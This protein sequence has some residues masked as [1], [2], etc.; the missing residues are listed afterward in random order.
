MMSLDDLKR[1]VSTVFKM[2]GLSL[3]SEANRYLCKLLSE[4][5]TQAKLNLWIDKIVENVLKQPLST[6]MVNLKN[7]K[8]AITE[9]SNRNH[10]S[11]QSSRILSVMDAFSLPKLTYSEE[12]KK[13]IR[14]DLLGF[15]PPTL[16]P[17]A[18]SKSLLFRERFSILYQLTSRHELFTPAVF[19]V[20]SVESFKKFQLYPI[21]YL[22]G[23]TTKMTDLVVLGMLS[24]IEEFHSGIFTEN[25]FVLAEGWYEDGIFQATAIGFPPI[26]NAAITRSYFG[27]TNFLGGNEPSFKSSAQLARIEESNEDAML[28]ILSEVWLDQVKQSVVVMANYKTP[29]AFNDKKPYNRWVEEIKAWKELTDLEETKQGLAI[30]LSLPEDDSTSIRDKVFNEI[31][32]EDLKKEDG[33]E[34]LIKFMDNI[35]KQDELSEAYEAYAEFDRHKRSGQITMEMY[36]VEFEKLYHRTKKFKMELPEA[37]R[38]F[39]LLE[40]A[41]LE[42]KDRQLVLTGVDYTE[43]NSLCKQMGNSLRKFFGKQSMGANDKDVSSSIKIE[44]AFIAEDEAYFTRPSNWSKNYRGNFRGKPGGSGYTSNRDRYGKPTAQLEWR[45]GYRGSRFGDSERSGTKKLNPLGPDGNPLRCRSCESIRHML[46]ECPDS[47][48]N[49][50][51]KDTEKAVLFT[52]NQ[53]DERRVF[54]TEAMTSAVLDSACTSTVAGE[55]WTKLYIDSLSPENAAQVTRCESETV[56]KFG[57]GRCLKSK[58]KITFPCLIAGVNCN[59]STDVVESDIPLLLSK[60][61]MKTAKMKLDLENDSA[62]IFGKHVDLQC[63]SSGHYCVSLEQPPTLVKDTACVLFSALQKGPVEKLSV[64]EKLHKQFAHPTGQRLKSLLRDADVYDEEYQKCVDEISNNC[65]V[66]KRYKKTPSRPIVALPLATEF[67]QVVAMDL[68]EWKP[69]VYFFHLIDM[70]TRFSLASV[71]KNKTPAVITEKIMTLWIGGGMGTP[72]KFLA[73]NGGEFANADYRD[74]AE[75]L[76][77]EVWNTAGLS[78]W[79]NGLCERNH[80]VVDDCVA[81]ILEDNPALK[82]D[83]ALVWAVNAKNALQMVHGWSPYQLVFGIN[84]SLPSVLIDQP[85]ALEGTTMNENFAK[86][87]NALHAGR[88]AFIQAESSERIRRA[89]R[90]QIR[91]SG[92]NFEQG[93]L[94][95]YKRDDSHRWKG[96]GK[97]IGQDG[98]VVFVRHGSVYIRVH[99]CR[100]VK[101]GR[102]FKQHH[103]AKGR[104]DR[105]SSETPSVEQVM[106]DEASDERIGVG[107]RLVPLDVHEDT[108][109][110]ADYGPQNKVENVVSHTSSAIRNRRELPRVN[111][112]IT[113]LLN[114]SDTWK[115]SCV[116]SRGGKATGRNWAYLNIQDCDEEKPKALN[117]EH[118]VAEWRP[119]RSDIPP[120][121]NTIPVTEVNVA[122]AKQSCRSADDVQSAKAQELEN[123]ERFDVYEEVEDCGQQV[124][125]TRWVITQKSDQENTTFTVKARLVARGFEAQD[126]VQADSPTAGKDTLRIFLALASTLS[127]NCRT[128]DIKAAFLQGKPIER[129][130]YLKPPDEA[131]VPGKL[132]KLKKCVYGLCDASRN[133]YFSVRNEL[134]SDGCYQSSVDLAL[135]HWH[136]EN[137]LAGLFIMHVDDFLWAGTAEFEKQVIKKI[138]SSFQIGK[139][140]EGEF[141]YI[142]VEIQHKNDSIILHQQSY[143]DSL[144]SIDIHPARASRKHDMLNHRETTQLREVIGQTNWVNNQTRPDIC[145]DV[146]ELSMTTKQPAVEHLVQANK[147]IKKIKSESRTL[148]FPKLESLNLLKLT[149]FSDASYANLPDGVSSAGGHIVFLVDGTGKCSPIS[150]SAKKIR[151]VVKSTIAAEALSMVDGLDT[152]YYIG[153]MI[154]E[155]LS[156]KANTNFIPINCYIDNR[157][158]FENLHS[159]KAVSEKRLRID[160]ATIKEMMQRREISHIQ[161]IEAS[162][163][164]SDCFTKRGA[165]CKKL[166]EV[167]EKL[168]QLFSG[169]CVMPPQC[170]IFIGDFISDPHKASNKKVV[171]ECFTR[172][173]NLLTDFPPL[174]EQSKFVFVPG[175]NDLGLK[176]I[177]PRPSIPDCVTKEFRKKVPNCDFT[178]NPA[179]IQYCTQ[180]IVIIREDLLSKVSRHSLVRTI[181]SQVHLSPVPLHAQP[182]YW[183]FDHA[184]RIYPLPDL[185]IYADKIDPYSILMSG[186]QVMNPGSFSKSEFIFKVYLPS[187]RTIEES[188]IKDVTDA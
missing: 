164:I 55:G 50:A 185:I 11:D 173:G 69:G 93:E 51:K 88:R 107:D 118:D 21:E 167:L 63:T 145:F 3:H 1:E 59:I 168:R 19:G 14:N 35:F 111:E 52:G 86:H 9:S 154:T 26:E 108:A 148:V 171:E 153:C 109:D 91:P 82:L 174:L 95:Y 53:P 5:E 161:W 84:P 103:D 56:F 123:W 159:T 152:A 140:A 12:R 101:V 115:E 89:L 13:F 71:I 119:L 66:C 151:R 135:F 186:T 68:K 73:D 143:I 120:D 165:S 133:W 65:Q 7:L 29:P 28:I 163:Q 149:L 166:V 134:L 8:T 99:P 96:P 160:L 18:K 16:Y 47:Y 126:D 72:K 184:L 30:A 92:E 139:E 57:G 83:V 20:N 116:I 74:M 147:L 158:L 162:N 122:A 54:V 117:F 130:V 85:P 156:M 129:D 6:T 48:E 157:S 78:P 42:K 77:I 44:P 175:P 58:E 64:V 182:I 15:S 76:N 49:M 102:E 22:L 169:Y 178:S 17:D 131:A 43:T 128:I 32:V 187:S 112:K 38:A 98:K 127:W 62:S 45:G 36:V 180:E 141:K 25:S 33:S 179:R 125:S 2:H 121:T 181:L 104:S 94:V 170:F 106:E 24:N 70:A 114:G 124:M 37:V 183:E 67:N 81:K 41:N 155:I 75:N 136:Y 60:S 137:K 4:V 142:G 40:G 97:V 23:T 138:Q 100:L 105:E 61:A 146:L 87:L 79:Q 150:W 90:H 39:K 80:A 132:W 144:T 172:L 176:G 188:Q 177:L 10:E 110:T 113:Y 34:T 27:N 46:K 31:S